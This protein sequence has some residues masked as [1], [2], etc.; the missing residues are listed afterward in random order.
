MSVIKKASRYIVQTEKLLALPIDE[1]KLVVFTY[2]SNKIPLEEPH[3]SLAAERL[4]DMLDKRDE[5]EIDLA[6]F[7]ISVAG[8]QGVNVLDWSKGV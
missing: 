8:M 2:A 3:R 5:E 1:A 6:S 4:L 7:I